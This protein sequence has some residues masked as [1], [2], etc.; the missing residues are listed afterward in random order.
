MRA[1]DSI[2]PRTV[3]RYLLLYLYERF[4]GDPNDMPTPEDILEG[5]PGVS[6]QALLGAAY[7][8]YD[9]G[10]VELLTGYNP[11]MFAAARI[12]SKG[13]DVV[14]DRYE[15][16]LHF[17]ARPGE[18]EEAAASVP[19]L[20]EQLVADADFSPLDGEARKCLLRDVMYLRDELARPVMRWR[21]EVI[22]TVLEWIAGY[23]DDP[24]EVLPSL[25]ELR[26]AIEAVRSEDS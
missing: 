24:D 4:M 3:R 9:K 7:Y 20:M 23:F 15:L 8:L 11:P 5:T 17:P 18:E 1:M 2:H 13:I 26:A 12:T 21:P 14:E 22:A 25:A 19:T 16:N 10:L 6:R